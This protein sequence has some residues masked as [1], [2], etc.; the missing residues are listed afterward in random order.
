MRTSR[1]KQGSPYSSW[2][3]HYELRLIF[4]FEIVASHGFS[5]RKKE[6]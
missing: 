5:F 3:A 1:H 2:K 4:K 6:E